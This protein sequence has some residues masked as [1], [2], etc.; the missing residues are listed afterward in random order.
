MLALFCGVA[1]GLCSA[2]S[3][4]EPEKGEKPPPSVTT[5]PLYQADPTIFTDQ[6]KYYL[7][8]TDGVVPDKGIRVFV[9]TDKKRWKL[10][11]AASGGGAVSTP[12][13]FGTRGFWAPQVWKA[14]NKFYM[15]YVANEQIAIG[16]A[17]SPEGPF[18]AKEAIAFD[19]KNIDPYVFFDEDG[20]K[21]L[22]HVDITNGNKIYVASI[23]DDFTAIDKKSRTLCITATAPWEIIQARV[24]EGP[25]VLRHKGIYYL[26]YSANHFE[27]QQYAV[28][29]ATASHPLGP[30]TKAAENPV[31]S[32]TNTGKPGS[33]HGD[34]FF[35]PDGSMNYVFHTHNSAT[36][37]QPRRTAV[38]K[39]SFVAD[40]SG[41]ADKLVMD[42]GSLYYLEQER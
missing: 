41:G 10:G 25:T 30:W 9:T 38:V 31:L 2:C 37:V 23:N 24:V 7:Y 40:P 36:S 28:G 26:I 27:N 34:V 17:P 4:S 3:K 19:Q 16:T 14:G 18:Y 20:K 22:Y 8:G 32:M 29:Y 13:S 33:G 1:A 39:A 11:A 35:D 12:G 6:G 5:Q 15:A 21:Y 42:V